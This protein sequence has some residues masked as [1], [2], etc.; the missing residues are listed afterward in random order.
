MMTENNHEERI[1][2]LEDAVIDLAHNQSTMRDQ[3]DRANS[4]M[5]RV[6]ELNTEQLGELRGIR[7]DFHDLNSLT[8]WIQR[9]RGLEKIITTSATGLIVAG[10][11]YVLVRLIVL[12]VI[13]K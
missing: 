2:K 6:I 13:G 9:R 7:E 4:Q 1:E 5:L 8:G 12:T 3:I 11:G 10:M